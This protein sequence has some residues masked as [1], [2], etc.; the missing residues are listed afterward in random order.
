[1]KGKIITLILGLIAG[2]VKAIFL[3]LYL[4]KVKCPKCK[5]KKR[6]KE[7]IDFANDDKSE[8]VGKHCKECRNN[9]K[10][11]GWI[12]DNGKKKGKNG[13]GKTKEKELEL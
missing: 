6:V 10:E 12:S 7:I 1:M 4:F 2:I 9:P 13:N 3:F 5:K 8:I 11:N